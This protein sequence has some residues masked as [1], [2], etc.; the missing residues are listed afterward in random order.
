MVLCSSSYLIWL[1]TWKPLQK[2]RAGTGFPRKW[3]RKVFTLEVATVLDFEAFEKF[4]KTIN[5]SFT[6]YR[7]AF[8]YLRSFSKITH[9]WIDVAMGADRINVISC[10]PLRLPQALNT[11]NSYHKKNAVKSSWALGCVSVKRAG[12]ERFSKT[13]ACPQRSR[14]H[15]WYNSRSVGAVWSYPHHRSSTTRDRF[16]FVPW[17]RRKL[18]RTKRTRCMRSKERVS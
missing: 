17:A 15:Q 16:H 3:T 5:D 10:A 13:A 18:Q 14:P 12:E 6:I 8:Q 7:S 1:Q 11:P 9:N 4:S 2:F